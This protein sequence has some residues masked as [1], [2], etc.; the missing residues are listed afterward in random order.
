MRAELEQKLADDFHFMKVFD[1]KIKEFRNDEHYAFE[2][3]HIE[4]DSG[5]GNLI[6]DMCNEIKQAYEERGLPIDFVLDQIKEKFA[7]LTVYYHHRDTPIGLHGI[8]FLG[9][10]EIRT[11]HGDSDICKT[12]EGIVE[13]YEKLST[14]VC[15]YC[16]E[17]G[18]VRNDMPWIKTLCKQCH[19]KAVKR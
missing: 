9:L 18:E 14:T 3:F 1:D 12:V 4:C 8:S 7:R 10:G 15:E 19:E 5:W 13:K 11:K 17:N 16:G 6:W 2:P